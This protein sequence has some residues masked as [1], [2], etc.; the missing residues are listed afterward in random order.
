MPKMPEWF[1]EQDWLEDTKRRNQKPIGYIHL[2]ERQVYKKI[3]IGTITHHCI[4]FIW[5]VKIAPKSHLFFTSIEE[6][7]AALMLRNIEETEYISGKPSSS[8]QRMRHK[9]L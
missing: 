9:Y 5:T 2:M 4:E 1:I 6:A 7:R 3:G 8:K